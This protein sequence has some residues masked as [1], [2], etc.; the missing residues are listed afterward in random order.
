M[1]LG[2]PGERD[3]LYDQRLV[4]TD[5]VEEVQG[6][7]GLIQQRPRAFLRL[8]QIRMKLAYLL[9]TEPI[10]RFAEVLGEFS[11][12][13]DVYFDGLRWPPITRATSC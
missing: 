5:A 13:I 4:Q 10:G 12:S 9:R 2:L 11:Y 8:N 6:A 7:D 1:L 3:V